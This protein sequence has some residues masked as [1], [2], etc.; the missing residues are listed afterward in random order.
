MFL[1]ASKSGYIQIY[2]SL[3]HA[4]WDLS[5]SES[6]VR[7]LE[8]NLSHYMHVFYRKFKILTLLLDVRKENRREDREKYSLGWI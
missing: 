1:K 5:D 6:D 2:Y 7:T 4:L 3:L 8:N